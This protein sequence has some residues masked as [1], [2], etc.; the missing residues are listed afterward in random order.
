V[1][2][3]AYQTT[4]RNSSAIARNIDKNDMKEDIDKFYL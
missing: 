4:V 1:R 3:V 2:K